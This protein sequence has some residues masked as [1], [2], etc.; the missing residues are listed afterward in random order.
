MKYL[1]VMPICRCKFENCTF[2][3]VKKFA[4][5]YKTY[6]FTTSFIRRKR[7]LIFWHFVNVSLKARFRNIQSKQ[8]LFN[9]RKWQIYHLS[10]GTSSSWAFFRLLIYGTPHKN[11]VVTC[12]YIRLID[13]LMNKPGTPRYAW[14]IILVSSSS[15]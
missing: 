14:C 8:P 6:N 13:I 9:T 15:N 1:A 3:S 4:R 11:T 12:R 10:L 7:I 2:L 5:T